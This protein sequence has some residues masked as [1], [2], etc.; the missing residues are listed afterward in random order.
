MFGSLQA[1]VADEDLSGLKLAKESKY[2][3]IYVRSGVDLSKYKTLHMSKLDVSLDEK[4][5]RDYNR[6]RK[7]L[8]YRLNKNDI[9]KLTKRYAKKFEETISRALA[10]REGMSLVYDIASADLKVEASIVNFILNAPDKITAS[11]TTY[12]VRQV[13]EAELHTKMYDA[14]TGE[15]VVAIIDEKETHEY[16]ELY[17]TNRVRNLS[18]FVRI[19]KAWAKNWFIGLEQQ[20]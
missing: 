4:W 5:L 10:Q 2:L 20:S 13:G 7:S 16:G 15:L 1:E 14:K 3:K 6:E 12:L 8:M 11:N 17:Q 18:E 9:A 19:Y